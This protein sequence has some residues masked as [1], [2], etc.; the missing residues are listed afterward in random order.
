MKK[1]V[2]VIAIAAFCCAASLLFAASGGSSSSKT[3]EAVARAKEEITTEEAYYIGRAV[4]GN[5]FGKYKR[6]TN[7]TLDTYLN[8]I[9]MAL[10]I[11]S[12]DPVLYNGYHVAVLD[13]EELN[14]FSTPG[15]HI[16]ITKGLVRCS[17][18]EDSLAAIIAHELAHIQL[19]HPLKAIKTSR[20]LA[21]FSAN[22]EVSKEEVKKEAQSVTDAL[23]SGYS[24][25]SE[26]DADAFAVKLLADT[27]YNPQAM[28]DMLKLLAEHIKGESK[29]SGLR[30]SHPS[31]KTRMVMIK[32][33]VF[34]YNTY[35]E[36]DTTEARQKRY[37]AVMKTL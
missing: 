24:K 30:K 17:N 6:Y 10:V 16:L 27:G 35:F 37:E 2:H 29:N 21:V 18:S 15:G 34:T 31:P 12:S 20:Q 26:F 4:A 22:D 33:S 3:K 36:K 9:C 14:A 25:Q 32:P 28:V 7:K 11:H 13:S 23:S 5:V 19:K 1:A 8:K